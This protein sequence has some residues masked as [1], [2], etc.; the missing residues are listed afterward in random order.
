MSNNINQSGDNANATSNFFQGGTSPAVNQFIFNVP[1]TGSS[2]QQQVLNNLLP[3]EPNKDENQAEPANNPLPRPINKPMNGNGPGP[4]L[5]PPGPGNNPPGAGQNPPGPGQNPPNPPGPGQNP[6]NPP[7]PGNN[8]VRS[9]IPW[10]LL[11]SVA[12]FVI[13]YKFK[14]LEDDG[15][16]EKAKETL[17]ENCV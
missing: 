6:P 4:G 11:S 8:P 5:N 2:S 1:S 17:M 16:I 9:R 3:R 12:M 14:G 13:G 7:G 10:W 15:S